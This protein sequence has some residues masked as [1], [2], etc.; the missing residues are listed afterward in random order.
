MRPS[1]CFLTSRLNA[2]QSWQNIKL[3]LNYPK[4]IDL[5]RFK[6]LEFRETIEFLLEKQLVIFKQN[7]VDLKKKVLTWGLSTIEKRNR[8]WPYRTAR[9]PTAMLHAILNGGL[10]RIDSVRH[11]KQKRRLT[12]AIHYIT[13]LSIPVKHTYR[14]THFK[15]DLTLIKWKNL[16]NILKKK[17][18]CLET[19][20]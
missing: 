9:N 1:G 20:E 17:R 13:A 2:P 15:H 8:A 7:S 18:I 12:I 14:Y 5:W 6:S 3:K 10:N 4:G 16:Q 19:Y 11:S